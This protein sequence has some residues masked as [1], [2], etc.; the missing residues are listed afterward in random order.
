M[1]GLLFPDANIAL[2][3][4]K[5]YWPDNVTLA[6]EDE[7]AVVMNVDTGT[8]LYGKNA[9]TPH[10][11]ASITKIM[12]A[13][14]AIENAEMDE[15]VTFSHDAVYNVEAG[16]SSIAR[17]VGEK[18]TM[19]ECLYGMMLE[20]AN[21]CAYAIAEH[22][23]GDVDTFVQMMNDKAAELGCENTHFANPHGLHDENHYVSAKDMAKIAA[24]AYKIR[25]FAQITGTKTYQIPPTNIH[26]EITYLN[27]HHAMLNFYKTDAYLYEYCLGGKTGYTDEARSTLVTYAK[28]D[29]N[30]LVSV[31]MNAISP[32]EYTD[33]ISLFNYCFDNFA[34]YPAADSANLF[35][36]DTAKKAGVLA[37]DIDLIRVGDDGIVILPKT[38]D[39]SET[40]ATIVPASDPE[41]AAVVGEIQ[42]FYAK[43][44][45]GGASLLFTDSDA[46]DDAGAK[47][48]E[49]ETENTREHTLEINYRRILLVL[50]IIAV[51][52]GL[53]FLLFRA[54]SNLQIRHR[55][56]REIKKESKPKYR[57]IRHNDRNERKKW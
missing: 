41:D 42:Y 34:V 22:V 33:T 30:M 20:S 2:A 36:T 45:V 4:Q 38:V 54:I 32:A 53:G 39:I 21:E 35:S 43:R 8:V 29:G 24:A 31:V 10:Y 40:S 46:A 26:H 23:G 6:S 37:T 55:R 9:D 18:M 52:V 13:M 50:A 12:T 1:L 16:S 25:K 44:Y 11:P 5:T 47:I 3:R 49:T 14:L 57:K 28:K 51:A 19:E 56:R 48:F 17:D 7:A 27:N 15:T